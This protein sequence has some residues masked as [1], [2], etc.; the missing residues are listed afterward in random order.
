MEE[1]HINLT[2]L[3]VILQ[4]MLVANESEAIAKFHKKTSD[5]FYQAVFK[6]KFQYRTCDT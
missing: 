2:L 3:S 6:F 4:H 5:S 1:K